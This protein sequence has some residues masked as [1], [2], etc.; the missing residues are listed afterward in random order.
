MFKPL[1]FSLFALLFVQ[2][3]S[4]ADILNPDWNFINSQLKKEKFN[5]N[6]IA[7]L[8]KSYE[9]KSFERTLQLNVLLFLRKT[10]D[11]GVQ[12]SP[13]AAADIRAFIEVHKAVL[14]DAEMKYGVPAEVVASLL[15][16]E[17]RYGKNQG[18]FHV[19]SVYLHLLQGTR[20]DVVTM[21]KRNSAQFAQGKVSKKN[22]K[23]ISRRA[24][25]KAVWAV[26]ELKSLQKMYVR[27]AIKIENLRGSFAGAF[28]MPQFLPSSY[29]R[30]A[31]SQ[32][33]SDP[34]D[35]SQARDAIYSV[36]YYLKDNGWKK[37][38]RKT[39]LK[40]LFKYNKSYDYA[41]AIF[42]LAK[43]TG[44]AVVQKE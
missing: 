16:L 32:N 6:F 28:G 17:S 9:Q 29:L 24:H 12:V 8:K 2:S 41:H 18:N 38:Q 20:H 15:W 39:H 36:A 22:L 10:D 23:E 4:W 27:H 25:A 11:H 35:L 33:S 40:A 3:A 7:V 13:G 42:N 37:G 26:G 5:K 30:W 31:K 14:K 1:V 44:D 43:M 19:P 34:A 21:L